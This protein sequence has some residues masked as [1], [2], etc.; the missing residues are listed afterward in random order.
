MLRRLKDIEWSFSN[1]SE[2]VTGL[3]L[4]TLVAAALVG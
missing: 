1:T 3:L 2:T 4:L